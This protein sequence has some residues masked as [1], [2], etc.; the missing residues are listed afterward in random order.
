L[1]WQRES[2]LNHLSGSYQGLRP[3]PNASVLHSRMQSDPDVFYQD[4][5]WDAFC[6]WQERRQPIVDDYEWYQGPTY[7]DEYGETWQQSRS[8]EGRDRK[9]HRLPSTH[10]QPPSGDYGC[11]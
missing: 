1:R 7:D 3:P 11:W 9:P 6:C 10:L 4:G 5:P 8:F 2:P